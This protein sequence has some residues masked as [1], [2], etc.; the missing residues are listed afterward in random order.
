MFKA[1]DIYILIIISYDRQPYIL[2]STLNLTT[3]I[4]VPRACVVFTLL[5]VTHHTQ[6]CFGTSFSNLFTSRYYDQPIC[7]CIYIKRS[8]GKITID[9]IKNPQITIGKYFTEW[10]CTNSCLKEWCDEKEIKFFIFNIYIK[11]TN[12]YI[13]LYCKLFLPGKI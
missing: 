8:D 4:F 13:S 1:L 7:C 12:I 2:L 6:M 5:Q 3:K 9:K 11:F 10:T